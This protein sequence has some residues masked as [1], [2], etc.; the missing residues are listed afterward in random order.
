MNLLV[1]CAVLAKLGQS[2]QNSSM[3]DAAILLAMAIADNVPVGI[4]S[5]ADLQKLETP[6]GR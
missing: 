6:P 5:E 1:F 4:R 3:D 2:T